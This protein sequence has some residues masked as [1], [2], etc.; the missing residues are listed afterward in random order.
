LI[1]EKPDG[2]LRLRIIAVF[3]ECETAFFAGFTIQ[4]QEDV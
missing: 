3:D 2:F 1:V 4:W